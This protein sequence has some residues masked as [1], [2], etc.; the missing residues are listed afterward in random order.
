V[1]GWNPHRLGALAMSMGLLGIPSTN[2]EKHP[3]S[4][5]TMFSLE[6]KREEEHHH[7]SRVA[8][9]HLSVEDKTRHV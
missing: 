3:L 7:Y 4:F 8:F 2:V 1:L 6:N 9:Y 5:L